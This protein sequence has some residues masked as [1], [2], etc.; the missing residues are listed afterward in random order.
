MR[1]HLHARHVVTRVRIRRLWLLGRRVT[2]MRVSSRG[3]LWWHGVPRMRICRS[4]FL[5]W[6]RVAGMR[7]GRRLRRRCGG[8]T[9]CAHV[10]PH[11]AV[12]HVGH[13]E[14]RPWIGIRYRRTQAFAYGERAARESRAVH[15]LRKD[16]ERVLPARL[17][18][19]VERLRHSDPE[20]VNSHRMH[21][22]TIRGDDRH[23]EAWDADVEVGHRGAVDEPETNPFAGLEQARPV[24]GRRRAV[25]QIR[26]GVAGDVGQIGRRH[27]HLAPRRPLRDRGA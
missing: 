7:I 2:R 23:L 10:V 26:V 17:D 22:L 12:A 1:L 14:Q 18:D 5:S 20:L 21:V 13:R 24:A 11:T 27:P 6:G 19:D 15:R 3:L 16:R 9:H 8:R 25:H 4:G